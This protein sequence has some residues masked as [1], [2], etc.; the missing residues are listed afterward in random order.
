M[1]SPNLQ[2]VEGNSLDSKFPD[3]KSQ[4]NKVDSNIKVEWFMVELKIPP[5]QCIVETCDKRST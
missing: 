5:E 3:S 1:H 2:F 4:S